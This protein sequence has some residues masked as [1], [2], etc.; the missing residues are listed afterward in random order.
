MDWRILAS[1][2][3]LIFLAELGDKTQLAALASAAGNRSTVSV[4]VG[5]AAALIVST[6]I[7]VL[8]G[9]ALKSHLPIRLVHGVAGITFLVLGVL[10]LLRALGLPSI[11]A[12]PQVAVARSTIL[13]KIAMEAAADFEDA[14]SVNYLDL[15][16]VAESPRLRGMLTDLAVEDRCHLARVRSLRQE[17]GSLPIAINEPATVRPFHVDA[18]RLTAADRSILA[19]AMKHERA[20]ADFYFGLADATTAG[21]LRVAFRQLGDE[22]RR[23]AERLRAWIAGAFDLTSENSNPVA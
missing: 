10:W 14:S 5:A 6:L 22:D 15:A 1:T 12:L 13:T 4:F 7:A 3:T 16:A 17:H 9:T 2:F 21:P 23:H 19:S 11:G 18:E 20:A 8:L